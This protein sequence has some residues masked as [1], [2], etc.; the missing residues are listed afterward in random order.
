[1]VDYTGW[2]VEAAQRELQSPEIG[3]TVV[4]EEDP[5]CPATPTPTVARQSLGPGEVPIRSE[6][7]L[8]VC[9]G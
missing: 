3:F 2:A 8:T 4:T 7:V 9:S 6:I 5:S 1:M